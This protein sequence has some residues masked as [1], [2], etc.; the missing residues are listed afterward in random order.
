MNRDLRI[1][2]ESLPLSLIGAVARMNGR[3][4]SSAIRALPAKAR[5]LLDDVFMEAH[6]IAGAFRAARSHGSDPLSASFPATRDLD[7]RVTMQRL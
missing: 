7:P 1:H 5:Q 6:L 2:H 3:F 4:Q